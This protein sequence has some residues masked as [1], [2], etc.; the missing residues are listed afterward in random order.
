MAAAGHRRPDRQSTSA[1]AQLTVTSQVAPLRSRRSGRPGLGL[2]R[3]GELAVHLG[4]VLEALDGPEH[5]DGRGLVGAPSEAR[6][7]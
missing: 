2:H 3:V 1:G 4:A 7:A 6:R 5:A